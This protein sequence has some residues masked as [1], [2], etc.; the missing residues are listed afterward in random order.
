MNSTAKTKY[1]IVYD[2]C[3]GRTQAEIIR[4]TGLSKTTVRKEL[5]KLVKDRFVVCVDGVYDQPFRL[6]GR[7]PVVK[8]VYEELD[9]TPQTIQLLTDKLGY[10][11]HYLQAVVRKMHRFG[12]L[13][14]CD[15]VYS[16]KQKERVFCVAD[17]E[18]DVKF[19]KNTYKTSVAPYA[20]R[21]RG[22]LPRKPKKS[23]TT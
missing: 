5:G 10:S 21:V 22:V 7:S 19:K 15:Y 23:Q 8:L 11:R 17:G 20:L 18:P 16:N 6:Y 14:V 3:K 9:K 12:M 1:S 4:E 2:C 13:R